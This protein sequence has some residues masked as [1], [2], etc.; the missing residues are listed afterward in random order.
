MLGC[1]QIGLVAV[2]AGWLLML[3]IEQGRVLEVCLTSEE[4]VLSSLRRWRAVPVLLDA[5]T[6]HL[7]ARLLL[8]GFRLSPETLIGERA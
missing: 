5:T 1:D 4:Q 8:A 3:Q 7:A 2:E 6:I